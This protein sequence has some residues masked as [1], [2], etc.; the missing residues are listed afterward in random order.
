MPAGYAFR[1]RAW[2]FA[3]AAA[4]CAAGIA[5]G[6]WQSDRAAQ[7]RAAGAA[8]QRVELRGSFE[9]EHLVYL[10]NKTRRGRPGYEI[11][12]PLRVAGGRHVLVNRG[13][14]AAPAT[15]DRLPPVRTPGGEVALSGVRLQHFAQALAPGA[16]KPQGMVW[17]N[18]T[19]DEF[20]A[21]SGLALEPWVLEQHSDLDDGLLRDW[22]HAGSGVEMHESYALQWYSLAA[23][24]LILFFA[25]SFKKN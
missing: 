12:Q 1:P 8:V 2:A 6:N 22:P 15:R 21:W 7:K 11:V 10:D 24:S 20:A 13:W 23:L 9:L 19:L 16:A 4:G 25:L 5:L 17:Q 3:L 14:T 18:V